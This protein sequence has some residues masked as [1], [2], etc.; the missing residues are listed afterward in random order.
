MINTTEDIKNFINDN[1]FKKIYVLCGKKSFTTSGAQIFFNRLLDKKDIKLFYKNSDLPILEELVE[2]IRDIKNFKPDL[3]IAVGG[4]AVIDYAK[5]ANVVDIRND[6]RKLIVSY[7]YP[8]RSKYTKLAVI[9][10]TAG[11]GAEV[12]SNAVIYVDGIK[13]SFESE[14]LIPDNFF[15]IPEFLISA[16]NKIKA[17]A[18]FDAI[19]QALESLVSK[20]S[21]KQSLEYASKSL[22]ISVNSYIP[23]L[24]NPNLKNATEMSIASNLAG[25]AINISKT[26]APHAA[27][28]PFTSLFNISHG[29]AVGLFFENFFKFNFDNL[30]KSETSFDLEK[31]FHLIFDLFKVKNINDF[32]TKISFIK[33]QA[34][35]EDNLIL[36]NIDIKKNY[37]EIIKGINLLRLG[38]NPVKIQGK[39]IYNIISQKKSSKMKIRKI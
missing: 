5:I 6:L 16:P 12:T 7:S 13:H 33:E 18:G 11:S 1:S 25:K 15:L 37:E 28:Y 17:S 8:F 14:L 38:N 32:N 10:T 27:S 3:I 23:F 36:L 19:A 31:R 39:D 21:N 35:L 9:P 24:N 30:D 26:T 29:H 20:K 2:I 4:G 22:K 34:K